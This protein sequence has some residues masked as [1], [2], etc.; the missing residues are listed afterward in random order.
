M[1]IS[2]LQNTLFVNFRQVSI[3][4]ALYVIVVRYPWGT[5]SIEDPDHC[6]YSLLRSLLLARC[7]EQN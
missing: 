1:K 5:V 2:I 6:D 7:R 4:G 3:D